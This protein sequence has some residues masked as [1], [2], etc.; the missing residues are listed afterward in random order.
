MPKLSVLLPVY[1]GAAHVGDAVASVLDQ[2]FADFELLI[3]DDA[4][5]DD[6]AAIAESF[7]DARVRVVRN[8]ENVGQVATLNRGLRAASGEYIARLD[9]DDVCLPARFERQV[10]VLDADPSVAVVGTWIDV[11]D[12]DGRVVDA[13]R[14]TIDGL[15]DAVFLTLVNRLPIAHP[16][17]MVRTRP[18]LDAGGYDEAVRYCE[19]MDLWRRLLLAG[20]G[21]RVVPEPLLRYRVHAGQQSLRHW[22][23][24]QANNDASLERFIA[25][26]APGADARLLRIAFTKELDLWDELETSADGRRLVA[27]LARLREGAAARLGMT[28][29]EDAALDRRIRAHVARVALTGWRRGVRRY[30]RASPALAKFGAGGG[31][32]PLRYTAVFAAAPA[33]AAARAVY[34]LETRRSRRS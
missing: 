12:D 32:A 27:E 19:D 11:V 31:R 23:E 21:I 20:R 14:T 30:R 3:L 1:N 18:V 28:S 13:L 33:L 2:T 22:D 7:G 25:A 9:Q 10:A 24:Q 29:D 34:R 8:E 26:L 17:V 4:S 6:S 16:S 15:A 5:P